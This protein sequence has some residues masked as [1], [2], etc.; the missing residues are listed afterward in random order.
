MLRRRRQQQRPLAPPLAPEPATKH[1]AGDGGGLPKPDRVPCDAAPLRTHAKGAIPHV[2]ACAEGE[3]VGAR[4]GGPPMRREPGAAA[5]LLDCQRMGQDADARKGP[6][7]SEAPERRL[8]WRCPSD[9]TPSW[10][11]HCWDRLGYLVH[12]RERVQ[13][14]RFEKVPPRRPPPGRGPARPG[15]AAPRLG[16]ERPAPGRAPRCRGG[17]RAAE[18]DPPL[19][20]GPARGGGAADLRRRRARRGP[21]GHRGL[22]PWGVRRQVLHSRVR[23]FRALRGWGR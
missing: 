14:V 3:K 12:V 15:P 20:G 2:G 17:G 23:E 11:S 8:F 16:R 21:R 19:A 4:Q 13:E 7:S 5:V 1:R 9:R 10:E 22:P 18:Q 6:E